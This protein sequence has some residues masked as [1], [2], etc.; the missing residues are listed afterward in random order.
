[1]GCCIAELRN[2]E[3]ICKLNGARV[4]NVDDVEIDI[5]NGRIEAIVIYGKNKMMGIFGKC[6]DIVIPWCDVDIIGED[7]ILINT[8]IKISPPM[9]RGL[10]LP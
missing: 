6:D 2:K 7:T 1:M 4:G 3:V 10:N 9:R 8:D 5:G